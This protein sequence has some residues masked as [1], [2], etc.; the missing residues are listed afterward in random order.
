MIPLLEK[1][2]QSGQPLLI[3]AE[4]VDGEALAALV[5]NKLRGILNIAAVKAPGFGD[6]R[7]A[8]LGDMAVLTGGT[9]ISE[10]L[11][12]KL[13][14][15]KLDQLG[16]AKQVKVNKDT[17]TII[18]GAGKPPTSPSGSTSSAARSRRRRASTTRRSSRSGWRSSPAAWP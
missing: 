8:M 5:V 16:R 17:T 6:R 10:D 4:D 14:N 7:K 2:A 18:Q 13:E 3:I 9:V 11:G 1:V 15:L 12:I